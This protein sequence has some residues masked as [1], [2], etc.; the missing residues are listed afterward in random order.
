MIETEGWRASVRSA[1]IRRL[2]YGTAAYDAMVQA[3]GCGWYDGGC[4]TLAVALHGW[5]RAHGVRAR[6]V[7]LV[8]GLDVQHYV[9]EIPGPC[10]TPRYLDAEGLATWRSLVSRAGFRLLARPSQWRRVRAQPPRREYTHSRDGI[11]YF[12][13]IAAALRRDLDALPLSAFID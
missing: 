11:P 1:R 13:E 12:A 6:L 7:G 4:L 5:L 9:I 10:G 2:L 8:L 3:H